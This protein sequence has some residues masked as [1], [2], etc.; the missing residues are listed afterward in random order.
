MYKID[1]ILR[2][3]NKVTHN[4]FKQDIPKYKKSWK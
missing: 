2:T 3:R 4:Y 1:E